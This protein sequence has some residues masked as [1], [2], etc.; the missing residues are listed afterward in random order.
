MSNMKKSTAFIIA[1][2]LIISILTPTAYAQHVVSEPDV[3]TENV[4]EVSDS[5]YVNIEP[6]LQ[7][8]SWIYYLL[9]GLS[10]AGVITAA[11]IITKKRD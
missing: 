5:G 1:S 11:V 10:V 7:K 6:E 2:L 8:T 4:S 9:G 3:S